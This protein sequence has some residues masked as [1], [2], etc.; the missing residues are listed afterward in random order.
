MAGTPDTSNPGA[1]HRGA[2][3]RASEL[4]DHALQR[5]AEDRQRER[6]AVADPADDDERRARRLLAAL[7]DLFLQAGA[8]HE[9][10]QV[11]DDDEADRERDLDPEDDLERRARLPVARRQRRAGRAGD[12]QRAVAERA[13][14]K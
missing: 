8:E 2:W 6:Q 10:V 4:A 7:A 11:R 13:P 5:D 3:H 9:V 12:E 14:A 1:R